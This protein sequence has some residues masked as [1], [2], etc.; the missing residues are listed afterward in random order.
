MTPEPNLADLMTDIRRV[1][2]IGNVID[3]AETAVMRAELGLT[4]VIHELKG[5]DEPAITELLVLAESA[6]TTL[7]DLLRQVDAL[8]DEFRK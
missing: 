5:V 2:T 6:K 4:G 8:S 7:G 3:T 1:R